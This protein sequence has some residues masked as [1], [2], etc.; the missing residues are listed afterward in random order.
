VEPERWI[1]V[2]DRFAELLAIPSA[3][4]AARLAEIEA[5]DSDLAAELSRLLAADRSALRLLARIVG[6]Q[7]HGEPPRLDRS[8]PDPLGL[9][10]T[11]VSH[12]RIHEVLDAGGMGVVYRAEDVALGRPVALKF[13]LPHL[14]VEDAAK[15]RFLQEA[16]A[17]SKLDHPHICTVHEVGESDAGQLFF[18]MSYYQGATL[19]QRLAR[20]GALPIAEA[21]ELIGQVLSALGAAHEEGILHRD[22][23]PANLMITD[24]GIIKVL[25][26]GIAK[27]RDLNLTGSGL[28]PG[29]AG[30]M[31]PEHLR[32]EPTDARSDLWSTGAVLYEMLTGEPPFGSG[33]SL[34]TLY[35]V[36]FERPKPP[37]SIRPEIPPDLERLVLRLLARAP[38]SRPRDA[39]TALRELR[40]TAGELPVAA[41]AGHPRRTE[42][43]G[44]SWRRGT[45]AMVA[46][47]TIGSMAAAMGGDALG[48]LGIGIGSTPSGAEMSSNRDLLLLADFGSASGDKVLAAMATEAFRV[49]LSQSRVVSLMEPRQVRTALQRMDRAD[50]QFLE[51]DLARELAQRE[52]VKA[53]LVGDVARIGGGFQ[54]HTQLIAAETGEVLVAYRR[55]VADSTALIPAI[56]QLSR[57]IRRRIGERVQTLRDA[58]PLAQVTTSSLAALRLYSQAMHAIRAEGDEGKGIALLEEAIAIDSTFA[59]AHRRLGVSL[60]NRGASRTRQVEALRRAYEHRSRLTAGE[61]LT[62][63]ATYH[64]RVTGDLPRAITAYRT[65]LDLDP[66]RPGALAGLSFLYLLLRQ[67]EQAVE[68]AE[69]AIA[70]DPT[71]STP[72]FHHAAALFDAG[73]PGDAEAAL[74]RLQRRFPDHWLAPFAQ[75]AM[76]AARGEYDLAQQTAVRVRAD[77]VADPTVRFW[78][79]WWLASIAGITGQTA[80]MERWLEEVGEFRARPGVD[81]DRLAHIILIARVRLTLGYPVAAE[82]ERVARALEETPFGS[83]PPLDRPYT[84]LAQFHARAGQTEKARAL[85]AE[86]ESIGPVAVLNTH[87]PTVVAARGEIELAE[88]RPSRAIHYFRTT[89]GGAPRPG[90]LVQLGRAFE[91]AGE[92]D[93]AII[94][95]ERYLSVADIFRASIDLEWRGPAHARL[96]AL[97]E[98]RGDAASAAGHRDALDMLWRDA[99]PALRVRYGLAAVSSR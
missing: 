86:W 40:A 37:R 49:D 89:D 74:V 96:A 20:D 8:S 76:Q 33:H 1:L 64:H 60:G 45:V 13:L 14:S 51:P 87:I 46:V 69:L 28:L 18:A 90:E 56:D 7:E 12:F 75:V 32:N 27:A 29:T 47:A 44:W 6:G 63:I 22:L 15:Q 88:G 25:D 80:A 59:M 35:R 42:P 43:G 52:G 30:Y 5:G 84:L 21:A 67:P 85:L 94:Y 71:S 53:I 92:P 39:D 95:F 24:T 99:D 65:L 81:A 82:Q 34:S 16:R 61:R 2:K 19:R 36:L 9:I 23:K 48:A 93:S 31:S 54:L 72:Y 10:G 55:S 91:A 62:T 70:A 77:R 4:R 79:A 78:M 98:R 83:V 57:R 50:A 41:A 97:Y 17:A 11:A 3:A 58:P 66:G 26:F 73:R 68:F 38:A